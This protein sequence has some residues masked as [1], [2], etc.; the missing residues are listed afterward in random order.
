MGMGLALVL[1][2][3]ITTAHMKKSLIEKAFYFFSLLFP[4]S[5]DLSYFFKNA[6]RLVLDANFDCCDGVS[7]RR[8]L[9]VCDD[10]DDD[11]D[12]D[13][14]DDDDVPLFLDALDLVL[15]LAIRCKA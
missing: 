2:A 4:S 6:S 14:D 7:V 1:H 3:V 15:E 8:V 12:D 13:V 11:G 9:V 10:D 5:M